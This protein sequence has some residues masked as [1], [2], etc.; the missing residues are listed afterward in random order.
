[1]TDCWR[2]IRTDAFELAWS[3]Q[4]P[5]ACGNPARPARHGCGEML[6]E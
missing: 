3:F 4:L 2:K 6:I 5:D 1:V